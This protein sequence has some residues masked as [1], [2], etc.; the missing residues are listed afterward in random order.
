LKQDIVMH[1]LAPLT[2]WLATSTAVAQPFTTQP[3]ATD[4]IVL[5]LR[6]TPA[7]QAYLS[8]TMTSYVARRSSQLPSRD[9]FSAAGLSV[10]NDAIEQAWLENGRWVLPHHFA[11]AV[12]STPPAITIDPAAVEGARAAARSRLGRQPTAEEVT[13]DI[14]AFD[15]RI[16]S[17]NA[18]LA[19]QRATVAQAYQRTGRFPMEV[20]VSVIGLRPREPQMEHPS[21][22]TEGHLQNLMV[23]MVNAQAAAAPSTITPPTAPTGPVIRPR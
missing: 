7:G 11:R 6:L 13:A 22:L 17:L 1:R 21:T 10:E 2:F 5:P 20:A 16:A 12:A 23:R 18:A 4:M 14:A 15:A 19:A 9:S 8:T 3:P